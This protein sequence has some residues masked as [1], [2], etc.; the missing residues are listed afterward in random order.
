MARII[1][2]I[3][4]SFDPELKVL[5]VCAYA[6]VSSSK[7][8]MLHSLSTQVSYYQT[9]IQGKKNWRFCGVYA[10]EGITGT[11]E[12]RPKFQ[13]MLDECRKGKI[14]MVITK[15]ISR[16]ARN[17]VT[18]LTTVRELKDLG[19][20]VFFE[21]Q[22]INTLSSD[23]EVML[24]FL[25]S[26]AQEE[27][28]SAS[29]NQKW[30]VKKNFQEGKPW[31][32]TVLGY[33]YDNGKYVIHP[34][35]AKVVQFIYNAFLQGVGTVSIANILTELGIRGRKGSM[36][37][38]NSVAKILRNYTYTGNLILQTTFRENH[39]TKKRIYNTGEMPMYKAEGTH[40]P[41][42]DM[43][44]FLAVQEEL[45]VRKERYGPKSGSLNRY[46]LSG[47]IKCGICGKSYRRKIR[48]TQVIWICST[49]NMRGKDMCNSKQIPDRAIQ[50]IL[51][52]KDPDSIKQIKAEPGNKLTIV[53]T[54]GIEEVKFWKDRS[55]A[56]AWTEEMRKKASEHAHRRVYK[57]RK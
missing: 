7:D 47:K 12:E 40:E 55:R 5:N 51:K 49:F 43:E 22:K 1:Q 26:Y 4:P 37:A 56:E 23:G 16:F 53:Y 11:K 17:T 29:E 54:G 2:Q 6:R 27:S 18:L 36:M 48:G 35:E 13:E 24:T 45:K 28:R 44:T 50:E 15:S 8:E 33:R 9:F 19:I 3:K 46:P 32:G 30:R 34:Q 38:Y 39:I 25:A 57:C 21:D 41:I 52:G 14:D 31:S 10:D 20:N 42:I